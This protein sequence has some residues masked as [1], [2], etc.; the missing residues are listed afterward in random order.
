MR[1]EANLTVVVVSHA[2]AE[3]IEADEADEE[4]L[5]GEAGGAAA[6]ESSGGEE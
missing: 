3:I 4:G 1:T 5:D 6:A 2:K